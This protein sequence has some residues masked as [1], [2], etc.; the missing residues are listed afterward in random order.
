MDQYQEIELKLRLEDEALYEKML[1]E[2]VL[3]GFTVGNLR[4]END[5]DTTYYDTAD[6]R[7]MKNQFAFRIR[8]IG[9]NYIATVKGQGDYK[10]GLHTR[11][12]WNVEVES[13]EAS[14]EPFAGLPVGKDLV[15]AVGSEKLIPMFRT[16]F[17]RTEMDVED[18]RNGK[19]NIA[20][21]HGVI[22]S[23]E[24]KEPLC[25]VELELIQ[26]EVVSLI[27]LGADLAENY[28]LFMER[29]SKYE[30]GIRLAGIPEIW[31]E[32]EKKSIS[33][34]LKGQP[35]DAAFSKIVVGYLERIS[36]SIEQFLQN[37][38][39]PEA[40]H[41]IR[42]KIRQLRSWISLM[43]KKMRDE[44]AYLDVQ[45][46]LKKIADQFSDIRKKDVLREAWESFAASYPELIPENQAL[47]GIL[48]K[49]RQEEQDL[50][51]RY[52]LSA[53]ATPILL[54]TWAW[55]LESPVIGKTKE[56]FPD[57][58]IKRLKGWSGKLEAG[59][60]QLDLGRPETLHALRI[61]GKKVRYIQNDLNP[62]M[63]GKPRISAK[64]LK[65][66]QEYL[67]EKCDTA[68][69]LPILQGLRLKYPEGQLPYEVGLLIGSRKTAAPK[70][71]EKMD[72]KN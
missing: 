41:Q 53:K 2:P 37:P 58:C 42:V 32:E 1:T 48:Q 35:L 15:R 40:A 31:K 71:S 4:K 12:E 51:I 70:L 8:K 55:L 62:Y 72:R 49:E 63:E 36:D 19:I 9:D 5:V 20:I 34:G 50:L 64:N 25:E 69:I 29:R 44:A 66:W 7:L 28:P 27:R 46:G 24:K 16:I 56:E 13:A 59:M 3:A 38:Q 57:Y 39:D 65:Q 54:N 33:A 45:A 18:G 11:A 26:G 14:V 61:L 47:S 52:S 30:R 23:G 21:D 67:G 17:H 60:K 6:Y 22:Q 68:F 43:K 10:A